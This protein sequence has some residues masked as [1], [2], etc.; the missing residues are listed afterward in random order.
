MEEIRKGRK[1]ARRQD[2]GMIRGC[3]H[4]MRSKEEAHYR[5]FPEPDLAPI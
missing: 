4:P 2:G 3:S 5:Y 1:V